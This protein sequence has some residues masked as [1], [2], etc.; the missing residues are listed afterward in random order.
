M[1]FSERLR[2]ERK[3]KG[4]SQS[5]LGEI[6]NL[7]KQTISSYENGGSFPG[8]EV[9]KE[10]ADFF[11]VS[12]DYLLGRT[13]IRIPITTTALSRTDGYDDDLPE[14]AKKEI[15]NFKE[16]IRQKYKNRRD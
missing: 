7:S 10:L 5:E 2:K 15:D 1:N 16:Y 12:V 11:D 13:D 8:Q 6:F 9:L 4:L 3:L 14:E